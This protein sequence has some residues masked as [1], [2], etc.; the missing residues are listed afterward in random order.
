MDWLVQC[1]DIVIELPDLPVGQHYQVMRAHC[2]Q[3]YHLDM[4]L[5]VAGTKTRTRAIMYMDLDQ[6][7][8]QSLELVLTSIFTRLG[9]VASGYCDILLWW[10]NVVFM[11]G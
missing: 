5:D 3:S 7:K 1:Q 4:I 8:P 2:H 9:L 6:V 11:R 10:L